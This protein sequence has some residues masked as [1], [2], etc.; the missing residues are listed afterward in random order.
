MPEA[1]EVAGDGGEGEAVAG[2][3]VEG[4]PLGGVDEPVPGE[5]GCDDAP[6]AAAAPP[7][8]SHQASVAHPVVLAADPDTP[9]KS[10]SSRQSASVLSR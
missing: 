5:A 3:E 4:V 9:R 2:G 1:V 6:E 7:R 8:A 10:G